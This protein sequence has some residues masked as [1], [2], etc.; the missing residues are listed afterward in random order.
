MQ[1]R[2]FTLYVAATPEQVWQAL[3]DPRQTRQYYF[4]LS[5]CSD[6]LPGSTITF[7]GGDPAATLHG[8]V[9]HVERGQRLVHS[10]GGGDDEDPAGDAQAWV[11][12]EVTDVEPGVSRVSLTHDDL[13]RRPDAD[14]DESW[15]RLLCNLKTLLETGALFGPSAPRPTVPEP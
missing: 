2:S 11:T 14:L 10:F 4:G 7:C 5:V 13:E 9:V 6:W 15:L 3:T 8:R 1:T 12:W